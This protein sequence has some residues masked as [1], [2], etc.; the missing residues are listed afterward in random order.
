M[1][2]FSFLKI[3]KRLANGPGSFQT[4]PSQSGRFCSRFQPKTI[5]LRTRLSMTISVV[6]GQ[7]PAEGA[8]TNTFWSSYSHSVCI[9]P[10]IQRS[11]S[12]EQCLTRINSDDPPDFSTYIKSTEYCA[13]CGN[14][15][16]IYID[17][18]SILL[19]LVRR[20]RLHA[21]DA[22]AVYIR[23]TALQQNVYRIR[24]FLLRLPIC[25]I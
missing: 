19:C 16:R 5:S 22:A 20:W 15:V 2:Q 23:A 25:N 10:V 9:N 1:L 21:D 8:R 7:T 13:Q 24:T 12:W 11:E 4:Q 3:N 18:R 14:C 6:S 17:E